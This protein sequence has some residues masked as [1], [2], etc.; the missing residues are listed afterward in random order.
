VKL[1]VR[2]IALT[3]TAWM[4]LGGAVTAQGSITVDFANARNEFPDGVVFDISVHSD[5]EIAS[6]R[7]R[8]TIPPEGANVYGEPECNSGEQVRCTFNLKS[9]PKLFLAP[10]TTVIHHWQIEDADGNEL[11]TEPVTFIYE[12]TRF[13]WKRISEGN[14]VLWYYSADE[15]E[16]TPVLQTAVEGLQRMEDLLG[17]TVDFPVKVFRYASADEMREASFYSKDAPAGIV[18]L[19]EVPFSDTAL[20]SADYEPLDVLRHELAHIVIRKAVEGPFSNIPAWL[21]EGTAVYAQVRPLSGEEQALEEAIRKDDV[22]SVRGMTSASLAR[23]A[24]NVSLFYGQAWSVVSFLVETGGGEKYAQLFAALKEGTTVD[25]ALQSVYGFDQNGL[26]NAWRESVGLSPRESAGAGGKSTAVPQI[27][28][29]SLDGQQ[30]N[31]S[32]QRSQSANG[33]EDGGST[34]VIVVAVAVAVVVVGG[35]GVGGF[36]L[37]RRRRKRSS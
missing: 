20:V 16:V 17:A 13:D 2:A 28:P 8:Y 25:K 3:F 9:S 12:D 32:S 36:A 22:L 27:T 30:G 19:G 24:S 6:V 29:F 10:G 14:L 11:E 4:L 34:V 7:F 26:D 15:S 35:L 37:A 1:M 21:D 31:G 33:G 23:S 18:T 5:V